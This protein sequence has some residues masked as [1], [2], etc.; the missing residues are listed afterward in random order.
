MTSRF[1]LETLKKL[2]P[3]DRTILA[4][5]AILLILIAVVFGRGNQTPLRVSYYSWQNSNIG[6]Q[7]QRLMMRFNHPVSPADIETQLTLDPPLPGTSSWRSREWFY[8][9]TETPHYGKNYQLNLTL[10]TMTPQG[11]ET[12]FTSLITSRTRSFIYIGVNE[13]E[14]GRLI[15]FDI[16][17]S[18][19]PKKII[20]TP[21]DLSVRQFQIYPLGDRLIF[22]ASDATRRSG[23]Q[24]LFTVITGVNNA[25]TQASPSPGRLER[26]FDNQPYNNLSLALSKNGAM[27]VLDRQNRDNPADSGLWAVPQNGSPRPLGIQGEAFIVSPRGDRLAVTQNN[28]VSIIPLTAD[29]GTSKF[30]AGYQQAFAFSEDGEQLL[31]GKQNVDF[32]FS[33]IVANLSTNEEREILRDLYPI[34]TC[35]YDPAAPTIAFCLR[36]DYVPQPEGSVQ[37][38]PYLAVVNL[39]TRQSQPLLALP[40]YPDVDLS[41]APDGLALIFDQVVTR[42]S[43]D[44]TDPLTESQKAIVDGR[45]WFL[46]IPEDIETQTDSTLLPQELTPGFAPKWMP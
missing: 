2:T 5:A 8:T 37:E 44:P 20:L 12:T 29:G 6:A 1:N 43:A 28:G 23:Q 35:H 16:T 39:A 24:H 26:L 11:G 19:D 38:E 42:D 14:R 7:T 34:Q 46:Q 32:T 13:E 22:L 45:V 18:Q 40:N 17:N 25:D 3:F 41:I 4:I 31:L 21:T 15:L 10:P 9:L 36:T 33:A 27:L 30:L